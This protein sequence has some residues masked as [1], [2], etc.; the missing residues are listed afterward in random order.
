VAKA[1]VDD[2]GEGI[3]DDRERR[4]REEIR[5]VPHGCGPVPAGSQSPS[6]RDRISA[7]IR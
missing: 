2:I 7:G 6:L 4:E 3:R 1:L 5:P